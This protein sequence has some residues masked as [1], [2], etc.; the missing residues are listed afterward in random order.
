MNQIQPVIDIYP[1][2]YGL[3]FQGAEEWWLYVNHQNEVDKLDLM[4][5]MAHLSEPICRLLLVHD[6]ALFEKFRLSQETVAR[7][8]TIH[9]DCLANFAAELIRQNSNNFKGGI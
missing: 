5:M 1:W 6:Q 3:G 9:A 8:C 7:L 4:L 2:S